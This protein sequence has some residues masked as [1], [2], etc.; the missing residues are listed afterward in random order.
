[1]RDLNVGL[2]AIGK[3]MQATPDSL[4]V[5]KAAMDFYADCMEKIDVQPA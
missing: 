2:D 1:M 5:L 4:T 3:G